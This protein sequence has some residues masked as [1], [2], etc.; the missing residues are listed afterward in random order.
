META[1]IWAIRSVSYLLCNFQPNRRVLICT[2]SLSVFRSLPVKPFFETM[3]RLSYTVKEKL[4]VI[5]YAR[6][7]EMTLALL[8]SRFECPI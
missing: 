7:K 2:I 5:R 8:F 1:E 3:G 6:L 4:E